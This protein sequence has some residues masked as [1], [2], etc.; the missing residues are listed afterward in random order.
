MYP[1]QFRQSYGSAN[2]LIEFTKNVEKA[3]FKKDLIS[4]CKCIHLQI[5]KTEDLWMNDEML[6]HLNSNIGTFSLSIDVW[7]FAFILAEQNQK[8][9]KDLGAILNKNSNFK[10]QEVDFDAYTLKP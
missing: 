3:S 7:N 4:A 1:Y 9:L 2:L 8:G 6:Y 5:I 10:R